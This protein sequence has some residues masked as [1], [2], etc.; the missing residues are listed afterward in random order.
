MSASNGA[1]RPLALA[2]V[3]ATALAAASGCASSAKKATAGAGDARYAARA[4][5]EQTV[6][7]MKL[8]S[9]LL[10]LADTSVQR[11]AAATVVE[12]RK[13]DPIARQRLLATRLALSS[14]LFGIVTGPDPIDGLLDLLT[15]TALTAEAQRNVVAGA[16]PGSPDAALRTA[17]DRNESEA[18]K[19]AEQWLDQGARDA[20][21]ARIAALPL[22]R[23][24]PGQVAYIRIA[25]LPRAGSAAID[26]GD[27]ISDSLRAAT[28]QA[29]QVR[30][31]AERSLFL[32]QRMPFL[33]RWQAQAYS[34]DTLSLDETQ[35]LLA[36]LGEMSKATTEAART[37]ATLPANV[38]RE[39][40]AALEDLFARI[41]AE[42]Q[43]TIEQLAKAVREERSA[44]LLQASQVIDQQR[45][46]TLEDVLKLAGEA[47]TRGT[48]ITVVVL[49]VVGLL[50]VLL[51]GLLLIYRQLAMRIDAH[52]KARLP[53]AGA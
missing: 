12:G 8:Q 9:G 13:V 30:L 43:L 45:K 46:G 26:A 32:M 21:R 49:V 14:A 6:D 20:L 28:Q 11:I 53:H 47:E 44:A 31:L 37:V 7:P 23:D 22:Q 39:R 15:H 2:V 36:Q 3:L 42:R 51:L 50:I 52:A 41:R 4:K 35:R 10:A 25:D 16:P 18:W 40:A 27:G 48:R 17:L 24:A 33:M 19:L 1:A 5:V 29:D 38:S 34:Y